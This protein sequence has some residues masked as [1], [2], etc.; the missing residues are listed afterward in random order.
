MSN[1]SILAA[2]ERMWQHVVNALGNKSDEG[3]VHDDRYYTET[4][5]DSKISNVNTSIT[6]IVNGTTTVK[7]A[8]SATTATTASNAEKLGNQSPSYYAAASAIPTGALANKSTVSESDL[9]STLAQKVNAAAQGNHSHSN[10]TV[11]DEIT[12][13]KVS[14]WDSA[15]SN[16]KTYTDG[17]ISSHS[18]NTA[19]T[20]KAGFMSTDMVTKLNGI[21]AGAQ[22]N[23][24]T[25]VKGD[26]EN[27]YRTGNVNITK[28]NIGLGNVNNTSDANKPVSTAQQTAIDSSLAS[29]KSYTDG[30]I[31]NL[32]DN[33]T[34]AVDS[35]MELAS[36]MAENADVVEALEEAVGK[37]AD[38]SALT[39]HTGNTSN[40]HSVTKSQV[41]LGNVENKSSSTIRSEITK[42]NVTT[43]LG[44]TPYTPTEVDTAL[45]GKA[46]EGHGHAISD[47][48]GLQSAL[49]SKAGTSH[50]T[51]VS[52]ST[53]APVMDGTAS[54]GSASTVARSDHK[55]PTDT[56]RASKT[57]FDNHA[58][59]SSHITD[60]ERTNWNVAYTH[61]QAA[62]APSDA[63]ANQNAFSNIAVSGQTTVAADTTTDTLTL[64]AGSNVTITTDATN[65]KVT[66]AATDTTYGAAGT[67]LGL[68]KSGGDVTISSGTITVN[69]DSHN[70][71]ISN[72]DNLQAALDAKSDT[73]HTHNYAG[74]SSV[75][76]A[77]TSANKVNSSLTVKL[78]SGTTEGT[79]M[80]T[81]NGSG[82][83]SVNITPSAIGASASGHTHDDRYYT[84]TEIDTKVSTLQAAINGKSDSGHGHS[85]S[86][87]TNLQTTLDAKANSADLTS[88]TGNKS[89]PHGV[90]L[91]QLGVTATATELNYVDGV[92][93]NVQ[94]QLN[95]KADDY[96]LEIYNG[97]GGNPKPVKFLT[98]NYSTCGSEN[99]VAIKLGLVS[100]HGN[101]SSY[102][103]LEDAIVRVTYL[104]GVEVDNFKYYGAS[105]GT[106]DGA[107][108]QY[109][110]IF[111]IIDTTNKVVDF[112]VLMGQYAR[113]QMTPYKRVTYSTGGTITQHTSC[114]VYSSGTKVWANNAEF[115]TKNDIPEGQDLSKYATKSTTLSGYGIT[116]AYT[117]A[118]MDSALA[119]KQA[120]GS[121]A[122]SSH[123]HSISNVTNLQNTLDAKVPTSRTVNGKA[124][125]SNIS[126]TYGDVGAAPE[127]H[128]HDAYINQNAFGK[129]T[130][131][132]TTIAA[133]SAI[134][135]LTLVAGSNVTITPDATNDKITI[136]A[137]DTKYTHP[138]N[139]PAS[140]ITGLATVATSGSYNDL[141][142]KPSIPQLN[143]STSSTSTTTA[144]TANAVQLAY[145]K[146]VT[147]Q[148][149][150]SSALDT[151]NAKSTVAESSTNGKVTVNGTD[152][153]VYEH[154]TTAGN[155]HIPTGGSSGQV[156]KWG[157]SGTAVWG[158]DNNTTYTFATGDNNGTI[159]V[160]PS[161]GSAQNIAVKGLG[162]VAY[163][164]TVPVA[165]GGTGA[166]TAS[167]AL[168]N[169]GV[170][171]YVVAEGWDNTGL[172]YYRK[173]N[174]GHAEAWFSNLYNT[175]ISS[176]WGSVYYA[177]LWDSLNYPSGLFK[178]PP[179]VQ[180]TS[181]DSESWITIK[182]GD[183]IASTGNAFLIC[184][185]TKTNAYYAYISVYANG[186][187]K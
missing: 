18:H 53:T 85:I 50:G 49:D 124:L 173:W 8:E 88:H 132:E 147:A 2:F 28:A 128:T 62:H 74:S 122:P 107:N 60:T 108:R 42:S 178:N 55:H 93:S 141:S 23:T 176:A 133:D 168:T 180:A 77:A 125:S 29:A 94:T 71:V 87:I 142:N 113:I 47:V 76:G 26:S 102:A 187:W 82:A 17:Q 31:A 161:G 19:T 185:V 174:S 153:K 131:G 80:F 162:S 46:D 15:E 21:A 123:T 66:I 175:A 106:Y 157:A 127:S 92:T 135:T 101:G 52:Y 57:E 91:A 1:T 27:S 7:K 69:D 39:S 137:T 156:L 121:Y 171:D 78:N 5:V 84:E 11:L 167:A 59:N 140:M 43:A 164:N 150:A 160:T 129:V 58:S 4:E 36:A 9:D 114:A 143:D 33:S 100:G 54:V 72:I 169:L 40:P 34:E 159:K 130:V 179:V 25:G 51:H 75:G 117:K 105:T 165:N 32:L 70:H 112:Y 148:A 97:T 139:H 155:K 45:S 182:S 152:I 86:N 145:S 118:E 6:N 96:S 126:L 181:N 44:Y 146:A 103:F 138:T 10:K 151:A 12:S 104:G 81:F 120:A 134:D 30:K 149:T 14:A 111:W 83:K 35:I 119:G 73:D 64:V 20:S 166:T 41:G 67:S 186:L 177:K 116:D 99:G 98:V 144:A 110:D 115:A 38:A 22:V 13:T 61:S 95:K 68:V 16:A 158:T 172:W 90:T 24:I 183:N 109:G 63:Q 170:S 37:K 3:H 48:S 65:D 56:S 163:T 184:P 136:A 89:N 79:N 154:P